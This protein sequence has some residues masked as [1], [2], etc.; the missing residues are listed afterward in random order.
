MKATRKG[1]II[2]KALQPHA[3]DKVETINMLTD[4]TWYQ[5]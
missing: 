3:G 5:P 4:V 1:A 2:G